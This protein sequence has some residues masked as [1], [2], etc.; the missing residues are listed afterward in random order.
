M[1]ERQMTRVAIS[2]ALVALAIPAAD[3]VAQTLSPIPVFES[4]T[5][6]PANDGSPQGVQVRVQSWKIAG[7]G[8]QE[9]AKQEIPLLGFYVAHLLSGAIWTTIDRQRTKRAPNDYWT[10]KAGAAMHV[11]VIGESAGLETIVVAKR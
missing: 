2:A 1:K 11:E 4:R 5:T 6:T 7:R 10:V 3:A 8:D 9:G